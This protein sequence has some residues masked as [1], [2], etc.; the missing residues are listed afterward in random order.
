MLIDRRRLSEHRN[1]IIFAVLATGLAVAWYASFGRGAA[2]WPGGSSPPGFAY[3]VAG[4]LIILF[5]FFLWPRKKLRTWRIGRV[6]TWM[7]AHIWLGLLAVPLLVMHSGFHFGESLSTVLMVLFL[8]VIASGI[9]GLV[10]Q[11]IIPRRML[12]EIPAETIYSQIDRMSELLADEG[13]QI[14]LATCGQP[15]GEPVIVGNGTPAESAGRRGDTH[16]TVGAVRKVGSVQGKTLRTMTPA[17]P[18]MGAELLRNV[19]RGKIADYLRDGE[20]S[21]SPIVDPNKAATVFAE[22]RG[23]C[24]SGAHEAISAIE[25]LCGQRRQFDRQRRLHR[26]LH[27]WLLVHLPLSVALVALMVVH[28]IV[29]LKYW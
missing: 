12:S 2:R 17:E 3:G 10:L 14:V 5:E 7:R 19:Y 21:R 16:I 4:G 11:Q 28:I 26:W 22:L 15:E 8:L 6:Q 29:T 27:G 20:R 24:P 1:W 18:I 13:E 25:D 9:Y 23:K